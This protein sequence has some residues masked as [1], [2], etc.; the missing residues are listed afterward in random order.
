MDIK[1]IVSELRDL[2]RLSLGF[3]V[4]SELMSL[5]L[6]QMS[7]TPVSFFNRWMVINYSVFVSLLSFF[8]TILSSKFNVKA[9]KP[10]V[11][12]FCIWLVISVIL[13][14]FVKE[15]DRYMVVNDWSCHKWAYTNSKYFFS[16]EW[17]IFPTDEVK[18]VSTDKNIGKDFKEKCELFNE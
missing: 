10:T 7:I 18:M 5:I 16:T 1:I 4:V 9:V 15:N 11:L 17:S 3:W 14:F 12:Y 2:L 13:P 8:I 6:I